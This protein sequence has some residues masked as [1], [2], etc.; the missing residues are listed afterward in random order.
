[1]IFPQGN[2][3]VHFRAVDGGPV[4]IIVSGDESETERISRGGETPA[5]AVERRRQEARGRILMNQSDKVQGG[6]MPMVYAKMPATATVSP[7]NSK[8][9]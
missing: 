6:L 9:I 4:H 1:M 2:L 3:P 8:S 7:V 5:E